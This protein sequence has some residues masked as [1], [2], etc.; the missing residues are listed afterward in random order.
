[1]TNISNERLSEIAT[2]KGMCFSLKEVLAMATE[3][4]AAREQLAALTKERDEARASRDHQAKRLHDTRNLLMCRIEDWRDAFAMPDE[5]DVEA[6]E[7][8]RAALAAT[9]DKQP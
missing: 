7:R 4:L 8:T 3:L 1:M 2:D 6:I 9:E 5:P